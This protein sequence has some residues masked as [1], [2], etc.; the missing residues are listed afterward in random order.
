MGGD[1]AKAATNFATNI[2]KRT[3]PGSIILL[4]DGYGLEHNNQHADKTLTVLALPLIIEQLLA[5][6]YRF[7]TVPVLLQVPAYNEAN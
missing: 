1:L 7:V 4:H 5:K 6:G 3:R 2:V